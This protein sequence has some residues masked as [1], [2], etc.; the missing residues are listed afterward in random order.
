MQ[1]SPWSIFA[2]VQI[3]AKDLPFIRVLD[4]GRNFSAPLKLG[5]FS[6]AVP[7]GRWIQIKIPLA[8]FSSASIEALE[9]HHLKSIVFSQDA[10]DGVSH[11][12]VIDEIRIDGAERA[13][14]EKALVTPGNVRAKGYERHVDLSWDPVGD[15]VVE[16]YIVY[17]SMDGKKFQPLGMQIRGIN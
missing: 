3:A 6:G 1:R 10:S 2:T 5:L 13:A 11:T 4:N 17:R 15:S 7:A 9:P 12:L 16:R 14:S 8:R